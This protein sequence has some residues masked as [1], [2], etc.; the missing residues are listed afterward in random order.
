MKTVKLETILIYI[1]TLPF[2]VL[3]FSLMVTVGT[4][5]LGLLML[6]RYLK[7]SNVSEDLNSKIDLAVSGYTKHLFSVFAI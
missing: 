1:I 4:T 2:R 5:L 6:R 3:A 7:R